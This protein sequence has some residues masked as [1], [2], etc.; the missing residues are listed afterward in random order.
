MA[1]YG[2]GS[3][4]PIDLMMDFQDY[5]YGLI[6][7]E[8]D[9]DATGS[10]GPVLTS[11]RPFWRIYVDLF[12]PSPKLVMIQAA[13][14]AQEDHYP[15]ALLKDVE[16]RDVTLTVWVKPAGGEL[17][18]G[19]GLVWRLRD[20]DNYYAALLNPRD[21]RLHLVKMVNGHA[22][23]LVAAPI[24]VDVVFERDEPDETWGWYQLEI[25]TAG[26]EIEARFQGETMLQVTD[27]TFTRAGRVGF[28]THADAVA[29]FDDFRVRV[30]EMSFTATPRPTPTPVIP[31]TMHVDEMYT[32]DV[33]YQNRVDTFARGENV[34]WVVYVV[35]EDGDPVPGC[36]PHVDVLRPDGSLLES[37]PMRAG[38]TGVA[39]FAQLI[40]E[41]EPAGTYTLQVTGI[42]FPEMPD[43]TYD[44]QADATSSATLTL[45]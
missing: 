9:F 31:P 33:L 27:A 37:R 22:E 3:E 41:S 28:C 1:L 8:F 44:P 14:L 16:A 43:A 12:A 18:Q 5:R 23:E 20:K 25:E 15:L 26:T 34:H 39:L 42:T 7:A 13:T 21:D 6:P 35:D 24:T 36:V 17:D 40:D 10:H 45:R 38:S 2:I 11:G 32:T 29:L 30:G 19:A 4:E